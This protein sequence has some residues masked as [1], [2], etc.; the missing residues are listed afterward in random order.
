MTP[1]RTPLWFWSAAGLG[2]AWNLFGIVQY[3]G[4]VTSDAAT[5]EAAGMTPEQAVLMSSLPG[6]MTAA[7]AIGVFGGA[8][9]CIALLL[10][11]TWARPV[12]LLSLAGYI[13]LYAGD[14]LK[15]VFAVMGAPQVIVLS[16][17]VAIAAGLAWLD[18]IARARGII[19]GSGGARLARTP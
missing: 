17:V 1:T 9:G 5:L 12:L 2:L 18:M 7:F 19:P 16:I 10:R 13:V 3:V 4:S 6:W 14:I 8:A 11:A 15:G